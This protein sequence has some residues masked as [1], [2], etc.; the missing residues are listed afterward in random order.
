MIERI[1]SFIWS[2]VALVGVS[3]LGLYLL[4]R[5]LA[6][7]RFRHK[8]SELEIRPSQP[9]IPQSAEAQT[10]PP[11]K[12][13][14]DQPPPVARDVVVDGQVQ[15]ESRFRTAYKL[16]DSGEYNEGKKLLEEEAHAK[17]DLVEQVSLMAFGQQVAAAQGSTAA[18]DDLR[19]TAR[20]HQGV[21]EAHL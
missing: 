9:Q 16:L 18:L 1:T 8:D 3:F 13:E 17:R 20:D 5:P 10:S 11:E 7:F 4:R 21:F 6:S 15:V 2:L 19:R 14:P 12:R